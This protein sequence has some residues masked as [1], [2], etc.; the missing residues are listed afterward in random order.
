MLLFR[1]LPHYGIIGHDVAGH[2]KAHSARAGSKHLTALVDV[3]ELLH[4]QSFLFASITLE[5]GLVETECLY[6]MSSIGN[7]YWTG[8]FSTDSFWVTSKVIL[9]RTGTGKKL[10]LC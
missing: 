9:L 1:G 8:N 2:A 10:S 4:Y 6:R 7:Q 5:R 3:H